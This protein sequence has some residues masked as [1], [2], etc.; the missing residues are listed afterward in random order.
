M[1]VQALTK[2]PYW[3]LNFS[4]RPFNS[5]FFKVYILRNKTGSNIYLLCS[6]PHPI[7][8]FARNGIYTNIYKAHCQNLGI[9]SPNPQRIDWHPV[10]QWVPPP[11]VLNVTAQH[12]IPTVS[13]N[14]RIE[15]Q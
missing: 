9:L 5:T 12:R 8:Y 3:F 4:D 11:Q 1:L 14:W 2:N 15:W 6:S 13:S 7:W 10:R